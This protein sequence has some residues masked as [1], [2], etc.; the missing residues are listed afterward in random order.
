MTSSFSQPQA[1]CQELKISLLQAEMI[2][3]ASRS[4]SSASGMLQ[5][6]LVNGL[7]FYFLIAYDHYS[8][9]QFN[10]KSV[11]LTSIAPNIFLFFPLSNRRLV[12]PKKHALK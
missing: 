6:L 11:A 9:P 5:N 3:S 10:T 12:L 1:K 7:N 4:W 2:S 8:A